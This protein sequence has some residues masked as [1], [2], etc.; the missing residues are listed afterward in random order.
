MRVDDACC[1]VLAESD[2]V[3][4]IC[5]PLDMHM[6]TVANPPHAVHGSPKMKLIAAI[7][8]KHRLIFVLETTQKSK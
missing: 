3:L 8:E 2:F 4:N 1:I 6:A 5:S 7:L